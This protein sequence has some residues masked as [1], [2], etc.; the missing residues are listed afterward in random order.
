MTLRLVWRLPPATYAHRTVCR[1]SQVT[2][3]PS[4]TLRFLPNPDCDACEFDSLRSL[5]RHLQGWG[6]NGGMRLLQAMCKRFYEHCRAWDIPLPP[7]AGNF[8]L[9]YTTTIPRQVKMHCTAWQLSQSAH[10]C[11]WPP[12]LMCPTPTC[13]SP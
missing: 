7:D 13:P 11:M 12:P 8:T 2:L 5:A 3:T 4:P 9:S 10:H 6:F 1:R